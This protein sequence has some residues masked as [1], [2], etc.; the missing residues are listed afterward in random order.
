MTDIERNDLLLDVILAALKGY[1][2][3]PKGKR[4]NDND[5]DKTRNDGQVNFSYLLGQSIRQWQIP[6]GNWHV[7]QAAK[8]VWE[9]LQAE[10][11]GK[12]TTM[13][14]AYKEPF[15]CHKGERIPL[16]SGTAK[17]FNLLEL[18]TIK[19]AELNK[20]GKQE[21]Q[22]VFNKIFIA[23]HTI[24]VSDI[25]DALEQCYIYN[26]QII[27]EKGLN[28][29]RD[30]VRLILDKIHITQMLKIEDRRINRCNARIKQMCGNN[31]ENLYFY[32]KDTDSDAIFAAVC[33]ECYE[34]LE[35][36]APKSNRP[37]PKAL[38]MAKEFKWA[39]AIDVDNDK[40]KIITIDESL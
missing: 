24:P 28:A 31:A 7:S 9:Y 19:A 15:I 33:K 37:S 36:K 6:I 30:E 13:P 32:L 14:M 11:V 21:P 10:R 35:Y 16:F 38:D 18:E 29:I 2:K 39:S 22:Y 17:K 26:K 34:N 5:S 8:D 40:F 3:T 25:K 20:R 23:E 1:V 12:N 27:K 4:G